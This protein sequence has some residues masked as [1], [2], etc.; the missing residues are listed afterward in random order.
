MKMLCIAAAALIAGGCASKP[1]LLEAGPGAVK[2]ELRRYMEKWE[3]GEATPAEMRILRA[4]AKRAGCSPVG[5]PISLGCSRWNM[6]KT[7][8]WLLAAVP[9][10][11]GLESWIA[12]KY[13]TRWSW[14]VPCE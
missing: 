3:S 1:H 10:S 12:P 6:G 9:G 8:R 4:A 11:S 13:C 2:V 14:E 5:P 7:S